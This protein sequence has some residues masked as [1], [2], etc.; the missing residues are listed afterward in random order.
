MVL[1]Q[2]VNCVFKI[3]ANMDIYIYIYLFIYY[4]IYPRQKQSNVSKTGLV[5]QSK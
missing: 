2:D 3:D 5:L 4:I 1:T